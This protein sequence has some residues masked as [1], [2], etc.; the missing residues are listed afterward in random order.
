M[1]YFI[2]IPACD[3]QSANKIVQTLLVASDV[4]VVKDSHRTQRS[5]LF[6]PLSHKSFIFSP[7][8]PN[9]LPCLL[10]PNP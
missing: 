7:A 9:L 2:S 10:L 8:G 5:T 1:E 3:L 6:P 4:C